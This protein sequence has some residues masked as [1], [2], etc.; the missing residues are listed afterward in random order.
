MTILKLSKFLAAILFL[1]QMCVFTSCSTAGEDEEDEVIS[2]TDPLNFPYD[3]NKNLNVSPGDSFYDYCNGNWLIHN[4]IPSDP[5]QSIGGLYDATAPMN[6][7]VEK[8]KTDVPDLRNFFTLVDNMHDHSE[9]SRAYI[10]AQRAKMQKPQTKEEAFKMIGE[11]YINGLNPLNIS[12]FAVWDRDKLKVYFEPHLNE[13]ANHVTFKQIQEFNSNYLS[14][15]STRSTSSTTPISQLA[16]GLGIDESL[17]IPNTLFDYIWSSYSVDEL[18]QMMQ[19]AWLD[20]EAYADAEGLADYNKKWLR[21]PTVTLNDLSNDAR[22][23]LNYT[24][25][26]HIQQHFLPQ[27]LKD[28]YLNITKEIQASLRQRIQKLDWMSET[29]KQNAIDKLDNCALNV[30]FPDTWHKDCVASLSDCQTMV[31][32]M[33]RLRSAN[34]RLLTKIIG[35]NDAFSYLLT[36]SSSD[37]NGN[38]MPM[39]LTLVNAAY[40]SNYNAIFIYPSMLLSPVMPQEGTSEACSYAVFTIIGHEFTH[41][42]DSS[43]AKYDKYGV[44]N[45]WWTVSDKM[46]FE[47]R[48]QNLIRTYNSQELDPKRAPLT[49]GNGSRTIN[50]NI[51]D[52]GGFLA[53][54]DAYIAHITEQGFAGEQ[55]NNQLR[56]FYESYAHLW[57]VEYGDQKFEILKNSDVHSH[58]RLRVNGVVMNTDLWYDLYQVN[59]NH[60]LYLPTERRTYIW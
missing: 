43:G 59:L 35:T 22:A 48:S 33:H 47:D 45:N 44:P 36:I 58:A 10:N 51:A 7:K 16:Q 1:S 25:S 20:Y 13:S 24:L 23:E 38:L 54:R 29:T 2:A 19:D 17:I 21:K 32:V 15:P 52:L 60:K 57:C 12:V 50:E 42:F 37:S 6:E 39:D 30:A 5:A 41:G 18:Y 9:A 53:A 26:Y 3:V 40:Q 8:L 28:K 55:F 31:E 46:N 27:S 49:F 14:L 4:P 11:M 56:K 34:A